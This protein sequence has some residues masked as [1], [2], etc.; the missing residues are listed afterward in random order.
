MAKIA[1]HFFRMHSL[2]FSFRECASK[3]SFTRLKHVTKKMPQ[4]NDPCLKPQQRML[5]T[6]GD[7]RWQQAAVVYS[8]VE[9]NFKLFSTQDT[10]YYSL[11][12]TLHLAPCTLKAALLRLVTI[13]PCHYCTLSLLHLVTIAPCTTSLQ[14]HPR[15][16]EA[17]RKYRHIILNPIKT[18]VFTHFNQ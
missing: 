14:L 10:F 5:N 3:F 1:K 7:E 15:F 2:L 17:G 18:L 4:A 6:I 13:A 8:L 16:K 11:N 9:D 12:C